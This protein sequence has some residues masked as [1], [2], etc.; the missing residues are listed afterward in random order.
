MKK[1]IPPGRRGRFKQYD[2]QNVQAAYERGREVKA[3]YLTMLGDLRPALE[4]LASRNIAK[5]KD[6]PKWYRQVPEYQGVKSGLNTRL[7]D[8]L[9]LAKKQFD[10]GNA[11]HAKSH[12]INVE[13]CD[14][15][16]KVCCLD[17]IMLHNCFSRLELFFFFD[18]GR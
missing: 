2:D 17:I 6:N 7:Q 12:I 13:I 18:F 14:E 15:Q 11:L 16:Y 9:T 3:Q 5:L 1:P 10:E 8:V 4:E